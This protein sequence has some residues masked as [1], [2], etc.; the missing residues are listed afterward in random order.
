METKKTFY[1]LYTHKWYQS[2]ICDIS[3]FLVWT[4]PLLINHYFLGS[5]TYLDFFFLFLGTIWLCA[6]VQDKQRKF[7]SKEDPIKFLEK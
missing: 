3:S 5:K 1:I 2:V 6:R 7:N 4:L